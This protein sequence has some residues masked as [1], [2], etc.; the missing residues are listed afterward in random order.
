MHGPPRADP[1]AH[2]AAITATT[3]T[4]IRSNEQD[5][6]LQFPI[7]EMHRIGLELDRNT[8]DVQTGCT[9]RNYITV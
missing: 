6:F 8:R 3:A 1:S 4:H 5:N 7:W 2:S 9:T